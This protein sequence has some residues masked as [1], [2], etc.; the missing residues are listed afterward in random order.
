MPSRRSKKRIRNSNRKCCRACGKRKAK[1]QFNRGRFANNGLQ[2]DCQ[3][4]SITSALR[5][6]RR[7]KKRMR[8]SRPIRLSAD[9]PTQSPN[10]ATAAYDRVVTD[11]FWTNRFHWCALAAGFQALVEG[12]FED[13]LY[14]RELAYH[15][16]ETGGFADRVPSRN[17]AVQGASGIATSLPQ[18]SPEPSECS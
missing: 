12:R 3:L 15:F 9:T 13:S 7:A 18:F 2:A 6:K 11:G 1:S 17:A 10:L 16:Y 8:N 14:V 5:T 4:C